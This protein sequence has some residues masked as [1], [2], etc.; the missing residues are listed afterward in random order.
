MKDTRP[1]FSP[2]REKVPSTCEADEGASKVIFK[3]AMTPSSL[4]M[5]CSQ[6]GDFR[7]TQ[8]HQWMVAFTLSPASQELGTLSRA[9]SAGEG[10]APNVC[11]LLR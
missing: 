6:F 1:S 4:P 3:R 7:F 2:L 5:T 11:L 8:A 10:G 9:K